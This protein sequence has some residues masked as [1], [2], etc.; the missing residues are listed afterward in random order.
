M[1]IR[2]AAIALGVSYWTVLRMVKS[3]EIPSTR[4]GGRYKVSEV[5]VSDK[6]AEMATLKKS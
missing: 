3:G 4:L 2:A 1:S 6:V 5:W